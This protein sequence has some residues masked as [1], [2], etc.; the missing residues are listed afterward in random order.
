MF[1]LLVLSGSVIHVPFYE[2]VSPAQIGSHDQCNVLFCG[3]SATSLGC[4]MQSL[5]RISSVL[6]SLCYK[7]GGDEAENINSCYSMTNKM[8][9]RA[10]FY[11]KCDL[12]FHLLGF[13]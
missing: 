10:M 1:Y 13:L 9:L 12:K 5:L 4:Q 7:V 11:W 2:N 6:M 8:N 3:T